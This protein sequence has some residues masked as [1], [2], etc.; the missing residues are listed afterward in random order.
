MTETSL[1]AQAVLAALLLSQ[2]IG[3][4]G[5]S[6]RSRPPMSSPGTT[7][8]RPSGFVTGADSAGLG[9]PGLGSSGLGH[10]QVA[11]GA[12]PV[13]GVLFDAPPRQCGGALRPPEP[14]VPARNRTLRVFAD[15]REVGSLR[16]DSEGRFSLQLPLG[17]Y[18]LRDDRGDPDMGWHGFL[19]IDARGA[20][21]SLLSSPCSGEPLP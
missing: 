21:A 16:S 19:E 14:L 18:G 5:S 3:C 9:S 17:K 13:Q 2:A 1:A 10:G 8:E 11:V 4:G 7:V 15:A 20:S 12:Q 6:T